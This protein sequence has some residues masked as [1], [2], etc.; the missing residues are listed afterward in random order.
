MMSVHVDRDKEFHIFGKLFN[1]EY[2]YHMLLIQ[3]DAGMGKSTLL[4]DFYSQSK[5]PR[6]LID[7]RRLD[8]TPAELL[9]ELASQ[10][11]TTIKELGGDAAFQRYREQRDRFFQPDNIPIQ[12]GLFTVGN[13]RLSGVLT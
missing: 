6:A 12:G 1:Y 4:E 7:L 5:Y 10:L 9:G 8:C 3:A 13:K 2:A 11:Q